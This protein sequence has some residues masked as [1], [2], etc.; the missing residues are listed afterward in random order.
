MSALIPW[1]TAASIRTLA[2]VN[3]KD[4]RHAP[5]LSSSGSSFPTAGA[6]VLSLPVLQV[7]SEIPLHANAS[8]SALIIKHALWVWS[9]APT[10][11]NAYQNVEISHF[12]AL[13]VRS[14]IQ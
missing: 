7:T 3:A 4:R 11:A 5:T 10:F 14:G 2:A 9:G 13:R 12:H 1:G 8:S 6:S